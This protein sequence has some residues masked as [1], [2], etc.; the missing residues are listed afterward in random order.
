MSSWLALLANAIDSGFSGR[1]PLNEA[2]AEYERKR[3][4][5]VMPIY[6]LVCERASMKLPPPEAM[7]FL[8]LGVNWEFSTTHNMGSRLVFWS[9]IRNRSFLNAYRSRLKWVDTTRY[10]LCSIAC[11]KN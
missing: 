2:L 6:N 5:T 11:L 3:N 10:L 9:P 7:Q 8:R 4:E 1:Q